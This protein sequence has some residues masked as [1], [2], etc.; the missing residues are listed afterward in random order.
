[1]I[2]VKDI[3]KDDRPREK[4]IKH[5][6]EIL[7]NSELLAIILGKGSKKENVLELS[8]KIPKNYN[9]ENLSHLKVPDLKKIFGIGDAKSC[10]IIACFE[11]GRRASS[12]TS[13]KRIKVNSAEDIAKL[14]IPKM[15]HLKKEY[16]K[17]IY[18]DS[19]RRIIKEETIFIGSID[20]SIVHP[21]EI[22][23]PA[24]R[25]GCTAVIVLHNHPSGSS[26]P[27][28]DDIEITSQLIKSG[29]ILGIEI[30]DH[31]IIGRNEFYSFRESDS[32]LF[33]E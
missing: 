27:S 10:Q 24:I 20:V 17:G 22:F 15:L 23:E 11:L 14:F 26:A 4:L 8:N 29:R 19:R 31:I 33:C 7:T 30:L 25:N 18:L 12:F 21:R 16:F 28:E 5:G 9:L 32:K 13:E 2:S 6:Q 1:M 3:I